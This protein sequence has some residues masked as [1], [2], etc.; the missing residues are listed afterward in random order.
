LLRAWRNYPVKTNQCL[1][2]VSLLRLGVP[3]EDEE[4]EEVKEDEDSEDGEDVEDGEDG[5][6]GGYSEEEEEGGEDEVNEDEEDETPW[7]PSWAESSSEAPPTI[8]SSTP[9][10]TT[11]R[12]VVFTLILASVNEPIENWLP[13]IRNIVF[14]GNDGDSGCSRMLQSLAK[15]RECIVKHQRRTS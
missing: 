4:D 5:E 1:G 3:L 11:R 12:L 15:M 14:E 9:T 6:D 8:V 2:D 10:T 7:S 13:K